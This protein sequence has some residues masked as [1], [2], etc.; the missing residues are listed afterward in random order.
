MTKSSAHV[1][2]DVAEV[3]KAAAHELYDQLMHDD[4]LFSEWKRKNPGASAKALESRF[5]ARNWG[6]CIPVA[7]AT[8][9][10][11]LAT[12]R[13]DD[14]KAKVYEALCLDHTLIRGRVAPARVLN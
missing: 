6:K 14:L 8:M 12:S 11:I 5:V 9:A 7:R 4:L 3:A 10:R 2:K 13:D 1:H